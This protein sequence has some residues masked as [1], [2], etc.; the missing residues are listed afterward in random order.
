MLKATLTAL[1]ANKRASLPEKL[2]LKA[3][4]LKC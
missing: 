1:T 3:A 2:T 4:V